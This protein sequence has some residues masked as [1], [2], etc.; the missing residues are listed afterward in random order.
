M[1]LQTTFD[2]ETLEDQA[3]QSLAD[4]PFIKELGRDVP[5]SRG[6]RSRLNIRTPN[7]SFPAML[8]LTRTNLSAAWVS[9]FLAWVDEHRLGLPQTIL[10]IAPY[11]SE[12]MAKLLMARHVSFMDGA[13]NSHIELGSTYNWTVLGRR[14]RKLMREPVGL[15]RSEVQL[16]CQFRSDPTSVNWPVR[17]LSTGAG[18]CKSMAAQGR[19][20]L[21]KKGYLVNE[22]RQY[23]FIQGEFTSLQVA[24]AYAQSLRP[25]LIL[26]RFRPA[27]KTH[28]AELLE[29]LRAEGKAMGCALTGAAAAQV[30]KHAYPW[31]DPVFFASNWTQESM[32]RLHL[33]PDPKGFVVV[34]RPFGKVVF[35][36]EVEGHMLAPPLLIWAELLITGTP[37]ALEVA[38]GIRREFM[39]ESNE[40]EEAREWMKSSLADAEATEAMERVFRELAALNIDRYL[41]GLKPPK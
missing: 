18:V 6:Y 41:T 24:T 2:G 5:A 40:G 1:L 34:L 26:G 22:D 36:R 11:V 30:L 37:Q 29:R 39:N 19:K 21:V 7:G 15:K 13:G 14:E 4:L 32:K 16:L 3:L 27:E 20:Q 38:A 23:R 12:P 17:R 28:R 10:L 35:W 31:R 9:E 8:K 25:K 33:V